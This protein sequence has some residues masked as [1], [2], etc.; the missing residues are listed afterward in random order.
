MKHLVAFIFLISSAFANAQGLNLVPNSSFEDLFECDFLQ[1]DMACSEAWGVL[2]LENDDFNTPDIAYEGAVFFPPSSIDAHTGNNYLGIDCSVINPEYVQCEL[3]QPLEAGAQYCVSF[4]ASVCDQ[5]VVIAPSIGI[6][7]SNQPLTDSPFD[8][9]LQADVEGSVI[10]DPTVWTLISGVYTADGSENYIA[11]SG[12][13]AQGDDAFIYMYVDDISVVKMPEEIISENHSLCDAPS[14]ILDA[15]SPGAEYLWSTGEVTPAIEVSAP[16]MYEVN[17]TMGVCTQTTQFEIVECTIVDPEDSTDTNT[18]TDSVAVVPADSL[19]FLYFVP[20][21][22]T[23]DGDGI[24]DVFRVYGPASSKYKF[25][26]FNRWGDVVFSSSDVQDVWTGNT[27]GGDYFVQDGIYVFRM[28]VFSNQNEFLEK[29][30][31]HLCNALAG[32]LLLFLNILFSHETYFPALIG[33][34]SFFRL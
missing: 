32:F 30:R 12:F 29:N 17:R 1:P 23:P 25:Q 20:N 21:A 26:V 13:G 2:T 11:V 28:E 6:H 18:P 14:I 27:R 15:F 8:L 4:Y 10:F 9:N 19:D 24:N 31:T 7:F 22:F 16:G 5:T 33:Y 3:S 34:C